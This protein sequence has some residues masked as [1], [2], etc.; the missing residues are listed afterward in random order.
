[1][2]QF[3]CLQESR[4]GKISCQSTVQLVRIFAWNVQR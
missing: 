4:P 1:M 2:G 3:Y